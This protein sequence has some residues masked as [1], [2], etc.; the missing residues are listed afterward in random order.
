[1]VPC[2]CKHREYDSCI[3]LP[4]V[5]MCVW[6]AYFV[7]LA[8]QYTKHKAKNFNC[9]VQYL[10]YIGLLTSKGSKILNHKP[11]KADNY[12][13]HM[14]RIAPTRAL[15]VNCVLKKYQLGCIDNQFCAEKVPTLTPCLSGADSELAKYQAQWI[16]HYSALACLGNKIAKRQVA[17][18]NLSAP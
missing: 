1:M 7:T 17:M 6:I 9:Y 13:Y 10:K 8:C 2:L 14:Q 5:I 15:I 12:E 16:D 3:L 18:G 11:L 4:R